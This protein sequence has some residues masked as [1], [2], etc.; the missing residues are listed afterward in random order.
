MSAG[1]GAT[2]VT[3]PTASFSATVANLA[4]SFYASHAMSR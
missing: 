4:V 3:P 1:G 2:P